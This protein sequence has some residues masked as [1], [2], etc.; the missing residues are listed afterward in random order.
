MYKPARRAAA[1][2]FSLVEVL[3]AAA[4]AGLVLSGVIAANLHLVRSGMRITQYAEMDSQ[5][6][7]A[8]EQF[9]RHAKIATAIKWNGRSDITFT[10]PTLAGEVTAVTYAWDEAQRLFFFVPGSVSTAP[11]GRVQL[12]R[13]I[14]PQTGGNSGV[15]FARFDRD[16]NPATA[17]GDTKRIEINMT[18][19]RGTAASAGRTQQVVSAS[20]TMRNKPVE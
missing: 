3:I 9:G 13:G 7:S 12:V 10:V 8:L 5:V 1:R 4:V 14:A 2:G 17:D 15:T 16:G 11:A 20:F 19:S 18:L 6:R